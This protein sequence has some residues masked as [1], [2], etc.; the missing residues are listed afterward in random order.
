M[1]DIFDFIHDQSHELF[2]E[3]VLHVSDLEQMQVD[4][5]NGDPMNEELFVHQ[6]QGQNSCAVV[7]QMSVLESITGQRYSEQ[8]LV[9]L[10]EDHG[11]FDPAGGTMP[12]DVGKILEYY[13]V[14][15]Q[16]QYDCTLEDLRSALDSGEKVIVGLDANEIWEPRHDSY[17][18]PVEQL[19][20]GHAVVVT[21]VVEDASGNVYVAMND[22]GVG[23]ARLVPYEDFE[24][25]WSD[26]GHFAVITSTAG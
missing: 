14:P 24:N 18:N 3:S 25:A 12:A 8:Q 16:Q 4:E 1:F 13:H 20:G 21:G 2:S 5:I 10:A 7:A 15:V 19:D 26:F 9:E 6:Q 23:E 11:W 22:S 17:G